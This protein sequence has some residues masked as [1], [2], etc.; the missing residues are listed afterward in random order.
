MGDS[1]YSFRSLSCTRP[2]CFGS[3]S[4]FFFKPFHYFKIHYLPTDDSYLLPTSTSNLCP[5][6]AWSSVIFNSFLLLNPPSIIHLT[7][8][9]GG[10]LNCISSIVRWR[11][12]I[13]M[14]SCGVFTFL[15]ELGVESTTVD[16]ACQYHLVPVL[17]QITFLFAVMN[18][19]VMRSSYGISNEDSKGSRFQ[20]FF[21]A[22]LFCS[23]R[24]RTY[25]LQAGSIIE[26]GIATLKLVYDDMEEV[27]IGWSNVELFA[28]IFLHR[29]THYMELF[30]DFESSADLD[31]Y[32]YR[33]HPF[34]DPSGNLLKHSVLQ[35]SVCKFRRQGFPTGPPPLVLGWGIKG[36]RFGAI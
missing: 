20:K 2:H 15:Q 5:R 28:N 36:Q 16:Q 33:H 34:T 19:L 18:N 14:T 24:S 32:V 27:S 29:P 35:H 25:S 17:K 12:M 26:C 22:L 3:L 9:W 31:C 11:I 1:W 23:L 13:D 4:I 8:R 10:W 30:L 21:C 6:R 7:C